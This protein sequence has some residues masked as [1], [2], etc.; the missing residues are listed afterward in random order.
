MN[1]QTGLLDVARHVEQS[2]LDG[3]FVGD[4]L[5]GAAGVTDC[6]IVLAVAAASTARIR[7]GFGVMVPALR[8]P[9]WAAKQ[10]A[11]LQLVTDER[12]ILGVGIGGAPHGTTAWDAVGVPFDERGA[13]TDTAL[14]LLPDL[15]AGRPVRIVRGADTNTDPADRLTTELTLAPGAT[16]PPVWIGGN[17]PAARHRAVAHGD[18]WFPSMITPEALADGVN[19]L[20]EIAAEHGRDQPPA[21]AAGGAVLLG[22]PIDQ[23][24]LTDHIVEL[25]DGYG[26]PRERA[27]RLPLA[28]PPAQIAEG[29]AAY[30]DAGAGHLVL[31]LIGTEWRTQCELLATAR[32]VLEY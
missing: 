32:S 3:V 22:E 28:G 6:T 26:I 31:G 5:A 13:H 10:V 27:A 24:L 1:A 8:H 15:I 25:V 16:P 18:A 19:H 2:G 14:S 17:S 12:V 7:I 20:A 11:T 23:T 30:A 4:H 29:L 9:V 21:S